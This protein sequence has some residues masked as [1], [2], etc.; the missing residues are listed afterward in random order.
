MTLAPR[1]DAKRRPTG[2]SPKGLS[3]P[4]AENIPVGGWPDS[5]LYLP[6]SRPTQ[7]GV[8]HVTD[9]G[10]VAV[11]A[12]ARETGDADAYGEIVWF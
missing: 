1:R 12:A 9:A 2:K 5:N 7:R 8:G 10:R 11:D 3:S 4:L 6:P